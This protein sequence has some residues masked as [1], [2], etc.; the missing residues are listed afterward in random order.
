MPAP[1]RAERWRCGLLAMV[2]QVKVRLGKSSK[3]AFVRV[4]G[5]KP[6]QQNVRCLVKSLL[7]AAN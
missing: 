5:P 6:M 2:V 7:D 1:G 4:F 3:V